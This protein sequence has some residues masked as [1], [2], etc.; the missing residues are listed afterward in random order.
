MRWWR[1]VVVA[2]DTIVDLPGLQFTGK[3]WGAVRTSLNRAER[4][5]MTFRLSRL[6]EETI[7][8]AGLGLY[9]VRR[10]I[11]AHGGRIEVDSVPGRGAKFYV[12]LPLQPA[13]PVPGEL[14]AQSGVC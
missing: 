11:D 1:G 12:R 10:L 7:P 9:V 8:G 14:R 2:D 13:Q 6:S 3:A 4:E 5:G